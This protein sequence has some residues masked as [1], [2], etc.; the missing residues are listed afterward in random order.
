MKELLKKYCKQNA[1]Y[2]YEFKHTI[3]IFKIRFDNSIDWIHFDGGI[4]HNFKTK[5]KLEMLLKS[6]T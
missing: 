6:L 2:A 1:L 5:E 4:I 3:F